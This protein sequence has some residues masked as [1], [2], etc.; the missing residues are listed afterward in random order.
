MKKILKIVLLVILLFFLFQKHSEELGLDWK[1]TY[2][3]ILDDLKVKN[4]KLVAYWDLI[5]EEPG[6]YNFQQGFIIFKT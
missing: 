6:V 3:A 5:E 4:L 1:K 2:L